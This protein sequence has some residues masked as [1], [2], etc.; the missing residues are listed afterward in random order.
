MANTQL[1]ASIELIPA[2]GYIRVSV[3]GEEKISDEIQKAS[4]EEAARR[5]G[6]AI[7]RWVIDLDATGRNFR[8][9]IMEAIAAVEAGDAP[10][11]WVWKYSRF[12]RNRHGVAVNLARV[13]KVGGELL[14]ATED[15]DASTATGKFTRG[16][17]LEVAAFESDRAGEGWQETHELRR[18]LGLPAAGGKRFGYLWTPRLDPDG[19]PQEERYDID[20]A[21]GPE[22]ANLYRM[23]I[24][25]DGMYVLATWINDELKLPNTRGQRWSRNGLTRY[26]DSGFGAGLLMVHSKE[27]R[28]GEPSTCQLYRAHY[29]Y[30]RGA[31]DPVISEETWRRYRE[32]RELMR[33]T[34][35][36]SRNASYALS[37]L[38]HCGRCN[39]KAVNH[40][41]GAAHTADAYRCSGRSS[42]RTDCEGIWM[43]RAPVEAA[44]RAWVEDLRG[45]LEARNR[46]DEVK[47]AKPKPDSRERSRAKLAAEVARLTAGLESAAEKYALGDIPREDYLRSRDRLQERRATTQADLDALTVASPGPGIE[48]FR[49]VIGALD[50]EWDVMLVARKRDLL[51]SMIRSV[52]LLPGAE[53]PVVIEP[54]WN[55]GL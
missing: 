49:D 39:G 5:K 32:R 52:T 45:E 54:V 38:V 50:E 44:V 53:H 3:W 21:T 1:K 33:V 43:K 47:P 36:R 41:G 17:L 13:E 24:N 46:G 40:G 4:I 29:I 55:Q 10:E 25:G 26:L 8:R 19:H 9:K 22:L 18:G 34:P 12:G 7:V 48:A 15:V 20:P 2:I 27:V 16:M 35:P 42:R 51:A 6:R 14:S 23:H 31:H 28:C 11:I 30:I 37:G